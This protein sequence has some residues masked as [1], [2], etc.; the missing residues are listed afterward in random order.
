MSIVEV[1]VSFSSGSPT[2]LFAQPPQ[3]EARSSFFVVS[4]VLGEVPYLG[5][6]RVAPMR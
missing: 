2:F 5:L 1:L 4:R 6:R 3:V